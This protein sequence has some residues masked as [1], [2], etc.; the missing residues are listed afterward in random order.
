V[1]ADSFN[2]TFA[3]IMPEI[4]HLST[5]PKHPGQLRLAIFPQVGE[6]VLA[7]ITVITTKEEMTSSA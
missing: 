6:K 4:C 7:M 1:P 5:Q 3:V 2:N